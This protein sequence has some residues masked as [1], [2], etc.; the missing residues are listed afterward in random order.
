MIGGDARVV[1]VGLRRRLDPDR[2][3]SLCAP[4]PRRR[5]CARHDHGLRERRADQRGRL[6]ARRGGVQQGRRERSR[7]PRPLRRLSDLLRRRLSDRPDGRR[8]P[9]ALGRPPGGGLGAG[10]RPGDRARRHSGVDRARADRGR[11]RCQRRLPRR[12]CALQRPRG[13]RRQHR[14]GAGP[15]GEPPHSRPVDARRRGVR[16]R[17]A[18]RASRSSTRPPRKRS[19]SCWHSPGAPS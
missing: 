3:R 17:R 4:F 7:C 18:L 10:D 2:R 1:R 16:P 5:A 12:R 15:L 11:R 13:D 9:Q 19:R 6:R 8:R 14:A